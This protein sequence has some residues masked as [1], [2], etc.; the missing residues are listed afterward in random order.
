MRR[1]VDG[2]DGGDGLGACSSASAKSAPERM[3]ERWLSV[4]DR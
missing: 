3:R 4:I 1:I 2:V